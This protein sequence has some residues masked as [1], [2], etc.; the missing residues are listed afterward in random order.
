M[1][2]VFLFL[3][4]FSSVFI[5][6]AQK[7]VIVDRFEDN[8][9]GWTEAGN[10]KA[11]TYISG[12]SLFLKVK[13]DKSVNTWAQLPVDY[14]KDFKVTYKVRL[15]FKKLLGF[16][17]VKKV[18][19]N[20]F[21]MF[22]DLKDDGTY[23]RFGVVSGK[24]YSIMLRDKDPEIMNFNFG[25]K[26]DYEIQIVKRGSSMDFIINGIEFNT[27][28]GVEINSNWFGIDFGNIGGLLS[29]EEVIIEQ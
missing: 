12:G 14:K 17:K 29:L 16:I 10:R 18:L 20:N 26:T 9:Y 28:K 25:K 4:F 27:I 11:K 23:N 13:K 2:K 6:N 22:F 1:K 5:V 21:N 7:N 24:Q 3:L 8:S 15:H 19:Q